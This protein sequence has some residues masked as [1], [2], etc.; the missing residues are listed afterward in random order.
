MRSHA[1]LFGRS[2]HQLFVPIPAGM[3]VVGALV[4]VG[5]RFM[6]VPWLPTATYWDLTV[7]VAAG[8]VV[9]VFGIIDW[10]PIPDRSRAKRIG[11]LHAIGNM[12]MIGAFTVALFSRSQT[13]TLGASTFALALEAGALV[14][15]TLTA[16]LGGEL[17]DR[18][19]VGVDDGA[20]LDAPNSLTHEL[21]DVPRHESP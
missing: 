14:M 10:L 7:G 9:G 20:N 2:L 16:W 5:Q 15:L 19:G 17:V 1:R 12:L 8:I 18:L 3:L 4:D 11:G 21:P 13:S 6:P